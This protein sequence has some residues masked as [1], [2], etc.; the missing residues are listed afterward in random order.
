ML[1]RSVVQEI[2]GIVAERDLTRKFART[3]ALA[4]TV[5]RIGTGTEFWEPEVPASATVPGRPLGWVVLAP[6][7][8]TERPSLSDARGRFLL[9]HSVGN[10]ELSAVELAL[11]T[12][13]DFPEE[14]ASFH[15]DWIRVAA[16]EV[17]HARMIE[18]RLREL[19]GELG[20]APVHLGLWETARQY[21]TP[22]ARL[23]VVPRILEARGLD[24]SARL[25]ARLEQAGDSA[26]A[27]V[28][29]RIYVD[30]IG[31]VGTGSRWFRTVSERSGQD[32]ETHFL[33]LWRAYRGERKGRPEPLDREGRLAAGFTVYELE[34]LGGTR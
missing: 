11:L 28:L 25:R 6:G 29:E 4:A 19:G 14:E 2:E 13:A 33:D 22:A 24:V 9:L 30:E 3:V 21:L 32:P 7:E 31:H 26:T 17:Q 10:I 34:V 12:A 23:A 15:R 16:E 27:K 1:E 18:L 5:E 20:A 8:I